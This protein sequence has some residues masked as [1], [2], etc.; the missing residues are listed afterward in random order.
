MSLTVRAAPLEHYPWL[1]DRIALPYSADMR[2][3]E[4]VDDE[5]RIWGMVGYTN[6]TPNSVR[7]HLS[8]E[9]YCWR[10]LIR[11]AFEYPFQTRGLVLVQL[12]AHASHGVSIAK[13]LGFKETHRIRDGFAVGDDLIILEKHKE[14]SDA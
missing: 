1:L 8:A 3:I 9:P 5:G 7:M 4:A 6:W 10:P 14:G 2:A 12:P 13:R 11:P